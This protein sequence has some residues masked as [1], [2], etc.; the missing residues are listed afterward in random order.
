MNTAAA[1]QSKDKTRNMV[2]FL[3]ALVV[4]TALVVMWERQAAARLTEAPEEASSAAIASAAEDEY[5]S[6]ELKQVVRRVASTCGLVENGGRG[7]K[8]ADAKAVASLAG[9]DFNAM[10]VPLNERK[11]AYI[12][13]YDQDKTDLD[14]GAKALVEKAWADQRGASF[15]FVV[16]RASNDGDA[17]YNQQL[18][19]SRAQAVLDHLTTKFNDPDIKNQV[20]LLWLGEEFAQLDDKFCTWQRSRGEECSAKDINRS[21]FIAWIDCNI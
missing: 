7:C 4:P 3:A 21:A 6:L 12:V 14:E 16:A 18:S 17:E 10:F 5:C 11:R 20:G 2:L 1:V 8:P 15:F 19:Q 13:Q 9:P